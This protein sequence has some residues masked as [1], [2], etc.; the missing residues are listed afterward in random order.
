[1]VYYTNPKTLYHH[2]LEIAAHTLSCYAYNLEFNYNNNRF[3]EL[4]P[5]LVYK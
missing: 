4:R 5:G 3:P 1:M 2:R